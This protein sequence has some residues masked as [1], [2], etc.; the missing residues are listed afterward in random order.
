MAN[1]LPGAIFAVDG[2]SHINGIAEGETYV[3]DRK[4]WRQETKHLS[5]VWRDSWV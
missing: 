4:N 1:R 3:Q 2:V 5:I